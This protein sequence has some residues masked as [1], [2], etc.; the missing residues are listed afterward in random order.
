ME[1]GHHVVFAAAI[2]PIER[3]ARQHGLSITEA[4]LRN[5]DLDVLKLDSPETYELRQC[6]CAIDDHSRPSGHA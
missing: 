1:Q 3:L 5:K 6:A 2:E 4:L